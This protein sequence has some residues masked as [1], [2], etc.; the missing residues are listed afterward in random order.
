MHAMPS[1]DDESQ[2]LRRD[3]STR[4][5]RSH[6]ATVLSV[7]CCVLTGANLRSAVSMRRGDVEEHRHNV[8]GRKDDRIIHPALQLM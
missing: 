8:D 5:A 2:D 7:F 6:T 4:L 3:E 1:G